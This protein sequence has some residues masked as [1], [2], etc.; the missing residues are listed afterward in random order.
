ME[1]ESVEEEDS[2]LGDMSEEQWLCANSDNESNNWTIWCTDEVRKW[3][4]HAV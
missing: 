3:C 1:Q 4:K 2:L